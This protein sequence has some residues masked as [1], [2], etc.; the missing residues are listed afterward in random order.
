MSELDLPNPGLLPE[1]TFNFGDPRMIYLRYL[2]TFKNT[3]TYLTAKDIT[4]FDKG[5]NQY[6]Q[7]VKKRLFCHIC[8]KDEEKKTRNLIPPIGKNIDVLTKFIKEG[9][10]PIVLIPLLLI[11]KNACVMKANRS[12][13]MN[14]ILYNRRTKEVERIDFKKFYLK[15]FGVK[16]VYKKIGT[17]FV[18]EYLTK[19]VAKE[20]TFIGEVDISTGFLK[21][22]SDIPA[23][24]LFPIY[25]LSYLKLRCEN[26]TLTADKV[27]QKL[28]DI[29]SSF[30]INNWK[31]FTDFLDK[32]RGEVPT[33]CEEDH[34]LKLENMTCIKKDSSL[35][36]SMLL[37]KP[38]ITCENGKVFNI[39]TS[40][41]TSPGKIKD[42][43]IML[44][45]V[46]RVSI[47]KNYKFTHLGNAE[48]IIPSMMFVFSKHTN[49][50]LVNPTGIKDRKVKK[51][52]FMIR[53]QWNK[54]NKSF[55]FE[56]PDGFWN[57]WDEGMNDPNVRF[58]VALITLRSRKDGIHANCFI[59]DKDTN[60]IERFDGL[61]VTI[62]PNYGIQKFDEKMKEVFQSVQG[63]HI[64]EGFKYYIPLDYC[65]KDI[66]QSKELDQVGY[67]DI[68]GNCA[69]WRLW[70]IDTRL[71]NPSLTRKQVVNLSMKKLEHFG[72]FQKFIKSYQAYIMMNLRLN[73]KN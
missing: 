7:K 50:F 10:K 25:L 47:D 3:S 72:S 9:R 57:S 40:K 60:E 21:R 62:H 39:F 29:D 19:H 2:L 63:T 56:I 61:G 17:N 27:H 20:P 71:E 33:K 8:V 52:Q 26:P 28:S 68:R 65:P 59:Y 41:C 53:W 18:E 58:I 51:D 42:V 30:I 12:K 24:K 55:N 11:N 37:E 15:K 66:Y 44:N 4:D 32:H 13:H 14:I 49:G 22:F 48:T 43:N 6:I 70:Y 38:A 5:D 31:S 54:T 35:Y 34:I 45:D 23:R 69:V 1:F 36:K 73:S 67:N 64:P 46:L 16:L